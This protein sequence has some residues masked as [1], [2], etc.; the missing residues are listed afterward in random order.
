M[1]INLGQLLTAAACLLTLSSHAIEVVDDR[2]VTV[3]LAAAPQRI[4]SVLPS[5]TETV[6]ALGQCQRLVGVDRYSN[7]PESVKLLPQVGGGLDPNIESIVALRPD[8]VLMAASS[9]AAERLEALGLKVVVC[10]P[11]THKDVQRVIAILG[12]LL[13]VPDAQK[14]W[15]G[16]ET[17][18]QAAAR[19]LPESARGKRVYFEVNRGL[20]G[21]GELSFIG[22]TLTR[23]GVKNIL[24]AKL[25]PFP[26][27][28]PEFVVRANPD[29]I[30]V[31]AGGF[32]GM[33]DR[34]GW[35]NI[36]AIREDGLCV[37][38]LDQS[39]VLVRP[40]PRMAEAANIMAKCLVDKA[41]GAKR[42]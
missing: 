32:E 4:V 37:F 33:T 7:W 8:V 29:V 17:S 21:A 27:I 11:K 35:S 5:L 6:C 39:D 28:N 12:R 26:K 25:G 24:P 31:G 30:M 10:E 36:R 13:D 1:R 19:S 34:P 2:G 20:Y 42:L 3:R 15:A 22:E 38:A 18:M 41:R 9:R 16:I 23:L 14:V 40:G